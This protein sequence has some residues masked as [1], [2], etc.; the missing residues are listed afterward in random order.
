MFATVC[1]S[2][3]APAVSEFGVGASAGAVAMSRLI[4]G[5]GRFVRGTARHPNA[6][7]DRRIETALTG[8]RPLAAVLACSDSRAPVE[9]LFDVGIGDLF[10]VRV[11]GQV[12]NPD[13]RAAVE[14]AVEHLDTPLCLVLGHTRCGAVTAVASGAPLNDEQAQLVASIRRAADAVQAARPDLPGPALVDAMVRAHVGLVVEELAATSAV[15]RDRVSGGRLTLAG[16]VYDIETGGL[17]WVRGPS[18]VVVA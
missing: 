16:A 10:V 4:E 2:L 1:S 13:E 15:I 6:G 12:C 7:A 17:E 18:G 9:L 8:Q 5:H 14:Y 3:L 11:P